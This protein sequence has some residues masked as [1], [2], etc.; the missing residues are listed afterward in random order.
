MRDVGENER[1]SPRLFDEWQFML[2][3]I[4]LQVQICVSK[5]ILNYLFTDV[6]RIYM[7]QN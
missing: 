2:T 1:G 6:Y 4:Q 7:R 3:R 5:T